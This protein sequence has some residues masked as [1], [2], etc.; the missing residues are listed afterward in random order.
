MSW[1]EGTP[2][3]PDDTVSMVPSCSDL[4]IL[5]DVWGVGNNDSV[6]RV[7]LMFCK[8]IL[9]VQKRVPLIS[10]YMKSLADFL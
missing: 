6:E 3:V 1:E 9:H 8:I 5:G 10:W 7:H 2:A 4:L